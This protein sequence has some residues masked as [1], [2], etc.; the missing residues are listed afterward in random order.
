MTK[1]VP[2]K[3][4]SEMDD[5]VWDKVSLNTIY[6]FSSLHNLPSKFPQ[7]GYIIVK[8]FGDYST[9]QE[10]TGGTGA[11]LFRTKLGLQDWSEWMA[12]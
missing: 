7:S 9:I 8:S 5:K 11:R 6:T 1:Y 12:F 3:D 2:I 10:V 4:I